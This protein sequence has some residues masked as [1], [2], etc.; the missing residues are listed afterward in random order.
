MNGIARLVRLAGS[1]K[2][3]AMATSATRSCTRVAL[4]IA[5]ARLG[6]ADL[7]A[8]F[9][10]L[11]GIETIASTLINASI[12][13]PLIAVTSGATPEEA[14]GFQRAA[15]NASR[16]LTMI[17]VPAAVICAWVMTRSTPDV[18]LAFAVFLSASMLA[19]PRQAELTAR[20][21]SRRILASE[22]AFAVGTA[23]SLGAFLP[24]AYTPDCGPWI[25]LAIGALSRCAVLGTGSS[26]RTFGP[27]AAAAR[28]LRTIAVPMVIGSAG[29][30]VSSRAQ[31][32][33]LQ[34]M[35][36]TAQVG[37]FGAAQTLVGPIRILSASISGVLRPRL[38]LHARRGDRR[39]FMSAFVQA[40]APL[41]AGGS[42]LSLAAIIGG[43]SLARM[44]FGDSF[45]NAGACLAALSI[46]AVLE[47]VGA[48]SAVAVQSLSD[49]GSGIVTRNRLAVAALAL[50]LLF[51]AAWWGGAVGSAWSLAATEAVFVLFMLRRLARTLQEPTDVTSSVLVA[52]VN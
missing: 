1:D 24:A 12:T 20:F 21:R 42:A 44:V 28:R 16:A 30:T 2:V 25:A 37:T 41:V 29:V 46:Y 14:G 3:S 47:A 40:L 43:D 17:G 13:M 32:F 49:S 11:L 39:A 34:A 45:A 5:I 50:A 27:N 19:S 4:G 22:V 48:C 31:P 10:L 6:D 8:Q 9:V 18:L 26:R 52:P 36:G 15:Y 35:L 51:P 23:A 7:F 38:A 33:V